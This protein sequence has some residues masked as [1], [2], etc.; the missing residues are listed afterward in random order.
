MDMN[1]IA[2]DFAPLLPVSISN[3]SHT[4]ES[5]KD[6]FAFD[7]KATENEADFLLDDIEAPNDFVKNVMAALKRSSTGGELQDGIVHAMR[8]LEN[9][10]VPEESS[11]PKRFEYLRFTFSN[12][13][14]GDS[15]RL[16]ARLSTLFYVG[17]VGNESPCRA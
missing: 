17:R 3:N 9:I 13:A 6:H 1:E 4:V 15:R 2:N 7:R 16:S 11:K 8:K 12:I 5:L 10:S 14:R